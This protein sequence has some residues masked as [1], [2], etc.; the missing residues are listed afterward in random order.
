MAGIRRKPLDRRETL[1][2][3]Q[4]AMNA[5]HSMCSCGSAMLSVRRCC[6][7]YHHMAKGP[8]CFRCEAI[9]VIDQ[10]F[11]GRLTPQVATLREVLRRQFARHVG[12]DSNSS[13][14]SLTDFCMSF[15]FIASGDVA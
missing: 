5:V 3:Q 6:F 10:S 14:P 9:A 13:P 15:P 7:R 11:E 12:G 8:Q 2:S 4:T 1:L